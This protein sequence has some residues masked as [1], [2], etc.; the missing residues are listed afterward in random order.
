MANGLGTCQHQTP[1]AC[2]AAIPGRVAKAHADAAKLLEP[3]AVS[4]TVPHAT[5][6][7]EPDVEVYLERLKTTIMTHVSAGQ[8]VIV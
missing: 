6:R 7:T 2:K 8:P 3:K 4:L 1:A 5:L